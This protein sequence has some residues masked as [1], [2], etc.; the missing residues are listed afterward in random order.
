MGKE[1]ALVP[2]GAEEIERPK[3]PRA[4]L[5][6][7]LVFA[8]KRSH[9]VFDDLC[10]DQVDGA[11]MSSP[12]GPVLANISTCDFEEKWVMNS[13]DCPTVWVRYVD[14]TFIISQ[15]RSSY[16]VSSLSKQTV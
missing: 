13:S 2:R 14:D 15:Q 9:F 12:L 6:N 5:K 8:T 1:L 11:A 3:T 16:Q 10:Y 4:V 7:L